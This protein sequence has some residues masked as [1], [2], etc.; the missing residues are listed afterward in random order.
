MKLKKY[1]DDLNAQIEANPEI[2]EYDLIASIDDEGNGFNDVL[3]EATVGVLIKGEFTPKAM[4]K[5]EG[6]TDKLNA[7]CLN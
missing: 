1:M 4:L 3:Y 6:I 7:I 2:L 5:S